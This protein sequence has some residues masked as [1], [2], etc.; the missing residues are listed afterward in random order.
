MRTA[1][2]PKF[3]DGVVVDIREEAGTQVVTVD[4][5]H[6]GRKRLR[7]EFVELSA[8]P[9]AEHAREASLEE[10]IRRA[11][12]DGDVAPRYLAYAS[13]LRERGD[14]HAD[15]ITFQNDPPP[16]GKL[17]SYAYDAQIEKTTLGLVRDKAVLGPLADA[18]HNGELHATFERGFVWHAELG[19]AAGARLAEMVELLGTTRHTAF[20]RSLAIRST[21]ADDLGPLWSALA[22]LG[23]PESVREIAMPSPDAELAR[24]AP[25]L[26]TA[27]TLRLTRSRALAHG[28]VA[29]VALERLW[30]EE[31]SVDAVCTFARCETPRLR[32][33]RIVADILDSGI[34]PALARDASRWKA[35]SVTVVAKGIATLSKLAEIE[36]QERAVRKTLP[37]VRLEI[38]TPARRFLKPARSRPEDLGPRSTDAASLGED[39]A[40]PGHEGPKIDSEPDADP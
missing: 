31:P 40:I 15:L 17:D 1:R 36:T 24:V 22:R 9:V 6:H 20:L 4:F 25:A 30:L 10:A 5:P 38:E 21:S 32:E 16:R 11:P 18:V 2:H 29:L 35:T 13:W 27:T 39:F 12:T 26:A 7:A 14:A 33:L 19:P 34:L 23:L 37:R 3:G 8:A 28:H